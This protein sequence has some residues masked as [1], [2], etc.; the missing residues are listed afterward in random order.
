MLRKQPIPDTT[1]S[2]D[3]E[4]ACLVRPRDRTPRNVIGAAVKRK[5]MDSMGSKQSYLSP[6]QTLLAPVGPKHMWVEASRKLSNGGTHPL[7]WRRRY[8][9]LAIKGR[10]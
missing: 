4:Q 6:P 10:N 3:S 5:L 2:N 1:P 9:E 8:F 7:E